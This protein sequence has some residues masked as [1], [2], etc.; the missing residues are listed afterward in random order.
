MKSWMS[1]GLTV[2]FLSTSSVALVPEAQAF[3]LGR[4]VK[5][6]VGAVAAAG[7]TIGSFLPGAVSAEWGAMAAVGISGTAGL[8]VLPAAIS[9]IAGGGVYALTRAIVGNGPEG[10]RNG[11]PGVLA[12]GTLLTL[13]GI[14]VALPVAIGGL[15]ALAAIPLAP[16]LIPAALGLGFL[17]YG[18]YRWWK[19]D[20]AS[21]SV[22]PTPNPNP[23]PNPGPNPNPQPP[24]VPPVATPPSPE[25]PNHH[26]LPIPT[27]PG[28]GATLHSGSLGG[29]NVSRSDD[30]RGAG[31]VFTTAASSTGVN[32]GFHH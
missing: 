24:V 9:V 8:F 10:W 17:G 1:V 19:A 25:P 20:H 32:T 18:I 11:L 13:A 29:A 5:G 7:A 22:Q 23:Q 31:S 12:G 3:D 27:L 2:A 21:K 26:P 6:A 14:G 28:S 30:T 15:A 16:I 4:V